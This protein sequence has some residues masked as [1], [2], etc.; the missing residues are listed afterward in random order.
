MRSLTEERRGQRQRMR[1]RGMDLWKSR[2]GADG[3]R[4]TRPL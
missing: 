4:I 3:D 1:L 2:G